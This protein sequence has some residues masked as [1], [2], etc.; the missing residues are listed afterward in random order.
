MTRYR[1]EVEFDAD[2]DAS[3][4]EQVYGTSDHP[5]WGASDSFESI[6]ESRVVREDGAEVR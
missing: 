3:A 2:D 1:F 5:E 6:H 4:L